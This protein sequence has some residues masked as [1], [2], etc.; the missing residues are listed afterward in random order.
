[1]D[2]GTG[3]VEDERSDDGHHPAAGDGLAAA[4]LRGD[5][6]TWPRLWPGRARGVASTGNLI[7]ATEYA[8]EAAEGG[9]ERKW[10]VRRM[11]NTMVIILRNN[12]MDGSGSLMN[13][14]E[15]FVAGTQYKVEG[16]GPN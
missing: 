11:L 4:M 10:G 1:M 13:G 6:A 7:E 9:K 2:L 15:A 16:G 5:P 8:S 3:H 14:I 12:S